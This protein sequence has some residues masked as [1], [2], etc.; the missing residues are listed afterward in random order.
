M[1]YLGVWRGAEEGVAEKE[2]G[3][4]RRGDRKITTRKGVEAFKV[5]LYK[6]KFV[7]RF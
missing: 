7:I 1:L 2:E 4:P 5:W 3:G 6:Q